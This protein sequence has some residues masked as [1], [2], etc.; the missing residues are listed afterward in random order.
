[1]Q[2]PIAAPGGPIRMEAISGVVHGARS[3]QR[4]VL[5]AR[6]GV[7]WVQPTT[8]R[9]FTSIGRDGKWSSSI[10]LG[11]EYAALLVDQGYQPA[12]QVDPLPGI[13]EGVDAVATIA[14]RPDPGAPTPPPPTFISFSGYEWTVLGWS[15]ERLGSHHEYSPKNVSL[16]GNGYLHLRI[17]GSPAQW[18]CS[19]LGLTRSLGYGTYK[20]T[21]QN[22]AHF[23]P[24]AVL[25]MYTWAE[26]P[27]QNHREMNVNLTRWGDGANRSAEFVV[28]P[29]FLPQNV[30]RFNVPSRT[31]TYSFRWEPGSVSFEAVPGRL[32]SREQ[33]PIASHSFNVGVPS[34]GRENAFLNFCEFKYSHVPLQHEAETVI[35]RFQY[36]P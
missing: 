21:V 12:P 30:F 6:Y 29:Y 3:D 5:F 9:P 25:S 14:G 10:H 1:M 28:Q 20:F 34:P 36:L 11:S 17:S 32:A 7:W 15:N 8:E 2:V 4:I 22:A 27:E 35:E 19:Q 31:S 16:D 33:P 13:G 18:T 24:A 26:L 23:E